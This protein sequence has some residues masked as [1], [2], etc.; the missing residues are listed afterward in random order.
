M[1]VLSVI[2]I[3]RGIGKEELTYF[4]P[5]LVPLGTVV[6][7][8]LRSRIVPAL[9]V[10]CESAAA[11]R[12]ELRGAPFT[13]KKI[14]SVATGVLSESVIRATERLAA[15][16]A[17]TLGAVLAS[18]IPKVAF[19]LPLE[20]NSVVKPPLRQTAPERLVFQASDDERLLRYRS[21]VRE[22]FAK[23]GSIAITAPTIADATRIF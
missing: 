11:H 10:K 1:Y 23:D 4:A 3:S 12:A 13:L 18:L 22:M 2:P 20:A 7:I 5:T 15:Y 6:R 14:K 17:A 8:P 19:D 21:L 16:H 9:V